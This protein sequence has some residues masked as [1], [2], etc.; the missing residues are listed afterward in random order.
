MESIWQQWYPGVED[1]CKFGMPH[2]QIYMASSD[3]C[4]ATTTAI[5]VASATEE[6]EAGKY[7]ML[8]QVLHCFFAI[9][10]ET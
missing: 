3:H 6:R 8:R 7:A 5:K 2:V 1:N 4:Q 9:A 10:I